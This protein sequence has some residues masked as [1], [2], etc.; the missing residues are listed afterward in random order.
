MNKISNQEKLRINKFLSKYGYCSRRVADDL[1]RK[2]KV[3]INDSI[4]TLGSLVNYSDKI[5][6]KENS[7]LKEIKNQ[8]DFIYL[9]LNKPL[10]ITSTTC[11][12][13][14]SNIIDFINY[15]KRI[16]PIGRLDKNSHGLILLTNNG[17]IVNKILRSK[18][19]H[20][21]EYLVRVNK[22]ITPDFISKMKSGVKIL[23]QIT[24]PCKIWKIDNFSFK[25]ILTQGLN[26]QIRRMCETLDYKV[27]YLKRTRILNIKLGNLK[28]GKYRHLTY[29]ELNELFQLIGI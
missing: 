25:I 9:A 8:V 15:P 28:V 14:K 19:N 1:I 6:I 7:S 22:K 18:N 26:R 17:D 5:Y 23:N 11:K 27:S 16:F 4:A 29:D 24:K 12:K 21:K 3:F 2:N 10:G 20:E 13:D